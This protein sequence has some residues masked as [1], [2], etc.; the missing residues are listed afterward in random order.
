MTTQSGRS[1]A[2]ALSLDIGLLLFSI[3]MVLPLVL[4]IANA[5]KTPQELLA[6][7]PT[8]IPS[9]QRSRTSPR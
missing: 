3:A 5:F 2:T 8:I 6:W 4:L 1:R 9:T 7:P